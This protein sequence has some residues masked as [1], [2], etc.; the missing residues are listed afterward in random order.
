MSRWSTTRAAPERR[1]RRGR[2][3]H[4]RRGQRGHRAG[5]QVRPQGGTFRQRSVRVCGI[6][7]LNSGGPRS[8]LEWVAEWPRE[9]VA[10]EYEVGTRRHGCD[11]LALCIPVVSGGVCFANAF[12]LRRFE[13]RC[14]SIAIFLRYA[15]ER[16]LL[17]DLL[18]WP[19]PGHRTSCRR[20]V[21]RNL[22]RDRPLSSRC[23]WFAMV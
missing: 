23:P 15:R 7:A 9:Y 1:L 17:R 8:M 10:V 4:V 11:S 20:V 3:G 16:G 6:S 22:R 5:H 18:T 19:C 12:S 21:R 14:V 13:S 2:G